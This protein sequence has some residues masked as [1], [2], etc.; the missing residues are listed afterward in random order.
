VKP[1]YERIRK[2]KTHSG[3][4]AIQVGR[5][6][7][8]HFLLSKH[9]GSSKDPQKVAD[10]LSEA[11][12]YVRA[13]SPQLE[14]DFNPQSSEIL[15]KRGLT[16]AKSTLSEAFTYLSGVYAKVGFEKLESDT[17]KHF[18][19][20]RVLEPASKSKSILLLQKY[21]DFSY[22]KTTAFRDLEQLVDL[23][24]E[25]VRLAI[26]YAKNNLQFDFSLVFYDV[27]TLYFETHTPDEF[28][29]NGFSK[30]NKIN[31]PQVLVGLVVDK[32]GF[33]VYYD[34]FR[35]NTFEGKT[36]I[37]VVTALR[38][39]YHIEKFTVI[40]DAGMLSEANLEDLEKDG[41]NYVVGARCGNL[42]GCDVESLARELG[43]TDKKIIKRDT[44]LYEY[45]ASRAKKDEADNDKAL[46]RAGY[47]LKNP[48]KVLR[49]SKFLESRRG[50]SFSLNEKLI[51]KRRLLEGIKGYKT[52]VT[53][54][55]PELLISRYK[56]LWKIEQS[57]RIAKSDLEARPIYHRLESSIKYHLLIVFVALCLT[58]VIEREKGV[59]IK[60]VTDELKDR[61]T[62]TLKDT[63]SGNTFDVLLDKKPH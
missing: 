33:P 30:D 35:G 5:Y 43:Q 53:N 58:R 44:V 24:E 3:A 1:H 54:L 56:D 2:V 27:T 45:S 40:A 55:S 34:I 47:Y 31:Q 42:K 10:L 61:W 6:V 17:L 11:S 16:V 8:K 18:V 41:L 51:K 62:I 48:A 12:A 63:I 52:N 46:T 59:T 21:F 28:R 15:F 29:R 57:F 13:H 60:R 22:K 19:I 36:I 14:L 4:V 9:V 32:T 23:K 37:P 25:A 39:T 50:G 38:Q 49:R 26:E 7:G 20:I